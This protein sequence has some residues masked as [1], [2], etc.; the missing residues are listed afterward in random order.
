M[1]RERE[2]EMY[3]FV[4]IPSNVSSFIPLTR[5]S[6]SRSTSST[7]SRVRTQSCS[8]RESNVIWM[9]GEERLRV[10]KRVTKRGK[11]EEREIEGEREGQRE[12]ER[13]R[14]G[15][16]ERHCT[17]TVHFRVSSTSNL[18]SLLSPVRL[19]LLYRSLNCCAL[20]VNGVSIFVTLPSYAIHCLGAAAYKDKQRISPVHISA[21]FPSV[22]SATF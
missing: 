5:R 10:S 22:E 7:M 3:D 19:T 6:A 15:Q 16:R 18:S 1:E 14:E 9:R 13:E 11:R 4:A 17:L 8:C 20:K 21:L 12:R 2:R